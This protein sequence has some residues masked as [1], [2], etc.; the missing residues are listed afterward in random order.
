MGP[1]AGVRPGKDMGPEAGKGPGTRDWGT[2]T[3]C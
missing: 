2:P 3:P 1:E